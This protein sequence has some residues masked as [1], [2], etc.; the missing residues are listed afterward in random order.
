MMDVRLVVLFKGCCHS[1]GNLWALHPHNVGTY[2]EKTTT[3]EDKVRGVNRQEDRSMAYILWWFEMTFREGT[4]SFYLTENL[5]PIFRK[6]Q[7][8]TND[9]DIP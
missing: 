5:K 9:R 3:R 7:F 6:Y 1:R 2:K 8:V 4:S